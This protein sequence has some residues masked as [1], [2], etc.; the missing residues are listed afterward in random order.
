VEVELL[1][2]ILQLNIYWL[3][4]EAA[5]IVDPF[6]VCLAV[7]AAVVELQEDPLYQSLEPFTQ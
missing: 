6:L 5:V 2:H 7:E 4:V 1:H 3:L